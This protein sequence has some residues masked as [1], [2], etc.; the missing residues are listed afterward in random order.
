MANEYRDITDYF[1]GQLSVAA[2][3]SDTTISCSDFAGLAG[4]V[5]SVNRVLPLV[6]HDPALKVKEV[7]WVTAHTASATSVTV[8]RAKESTVARAWG[9]GTQ[10]LCAPTVRDG[11]LVAARASLPSDANWGA[12][13][14]VSDEGIV[15]ERA[16]AGWGPSVGT[17]Q[18]AEMGPRISG[19]I[20]AGAVITR[21]AGY[22]AGTT[23]G[24]GKLAV[25]YP[26]GFTNATIAPQVTLL[27]ASASIELGATDVTASGFNLIAYRCSDGLPSTS[28]SVTC[29]WGADGY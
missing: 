23:N 26:V 1:F 16:G 14:A 2:S 19:T 10:I 3:I 18:P 20:P 8:V 24:S 17:A 29:W 25:A 15:V 6:L 21:R 13:V 11:L 9:A 4:G 12:R 27:D 7:V 22:K 28:T 5:Y